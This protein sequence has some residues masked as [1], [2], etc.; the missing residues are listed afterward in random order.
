VFVWCRLSRFYFESAKRR[1]YFL[2]PD[3]LERRSSQ[4]ALEEILDV[5]TR[6]LAPIT[7]FLA[8]E[9]RTAPKNDIVKII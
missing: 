4:T 5:L 1:L 2:D 9:V 7:S 3:C 8:E 6:L